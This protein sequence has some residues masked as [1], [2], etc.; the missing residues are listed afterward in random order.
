MAGFYGNNT[1]AAQQMYGQPI[2]SMQFGSWNNSYTTMP[3]P[4]QNSGVIWV[5]GI[6]GAKG[7]IIQ[8]N[9]TVV[10]MDSERNY[11]YLKT[12]NEAGIASIRIFEFQEK[13]QVEPKSS[14]DI[15]SKLKDFVS[16]EEFEELKAS[17]AALKPQP[18]YVEKEKKGV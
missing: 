16:R 8:P 1:L 3:K 18:K 4:Q 2:N 12:A 11:F 14:V 15:D 5:N 7:Y 17:I 9:S 6:E 13:H 10:L